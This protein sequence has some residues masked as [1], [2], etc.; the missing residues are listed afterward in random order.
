MSKPDYTEVARISA[1]NQCYKPGDMVLVVGD[2]G[3]IFRDKVRY[4]ASL[5]GG[6]TA[7][8]WLETIG[9]YA[10]NRVVGKEAEA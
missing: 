6:H 9:T 5:L 7:V 4:P 3:E 1:F 10:L 2:R 8:A